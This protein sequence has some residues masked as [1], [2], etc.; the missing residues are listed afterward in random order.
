[1][2]T[3]N[4]RV[5]THEITLQNLVEVVRYF[6][7][8][9]TLDYLTPKQVSSLKTI[10]SKECVD[11]RRKGMRDILIKLLTEKNLISKLRSISFEQMEFQGDINPTILAISRTKKSGAYDLETLRS[12][13]RKLGI[14][15]TSR[16][17]KSLLV[18]KISPFVRDHVLDT[19][20]AIFEKLMYC[21]ESIDHFPPQKV[22]KLKELTLSKQ[23]QIIDI[24]SRVF[25]S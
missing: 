2:S 5:L 4:S 8:E 7:S 6:K 3:S 25:D 10:V 13:C 15:Y 19:P 23:E 9:N 14:D 12:I 20:E 1:M 24:L 17:S 21:I 11:E 18:D 22:R 16:D